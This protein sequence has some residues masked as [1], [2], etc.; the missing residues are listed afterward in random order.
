MR[1]K[2]CIGKSDES[3]PL[4]SLGPWY[5]Y[6]LR[7][8]TG[9]LYTGISTDPPRRMQ[10]HEACK[11][12]ARSL[13]GKGPFVLVW[14]QAANNRSDASKLET[15]IKKLG[16]IAKEKLVSEGAAF[17]LQRAGNAEKA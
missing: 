4:A 2:K 9:L 10:Q 14:Q 15:G 17:V 11:A 5:V 6:M 7:T 1:D 16:K 13:R 8:R 3:K 12:G